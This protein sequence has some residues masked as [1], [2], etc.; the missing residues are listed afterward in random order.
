VLELTSVGGGSR[1]CF[2]GNT[3]LEL[4][5]RDRVA[6]RRVRSGLRA[7]ED[8]FA[9]VVRRGIAAGELRA[10][11]PPAQA[12]QFLV[13]GVQGMLVMAKAGADRATLAALR[14]TLLSVVTH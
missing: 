6:R 13:S 4:G 10:T 9:Q 8:I 5:G 3:S 1:G 11:V 7:V 12:A 14:K 2:L